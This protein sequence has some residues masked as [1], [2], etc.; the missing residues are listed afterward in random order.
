VSE[1]GGERS[2]RIKIGARWMAGVTGESVG[3]GFAG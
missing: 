1:I 2:E 3:N